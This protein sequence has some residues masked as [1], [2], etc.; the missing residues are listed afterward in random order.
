MSLMHL[1]KLSLVFWYKDRL[2]CDGVVYMLIVRRQILH[3]TKLLF[4]LMLLTSWGMRNMP[5]FIYEDM[6]CAMG[7]ASGS[8][9]LSRLRD[10]MLQDEE[11]RQI[12]W[13]VTIL[14]HGS[15]TSVCGSKNRQLWKAAKSFIRDL[16]QLLRQ[17]SWD[18]R[19]K[20]LQTSHEIL[21]INYK[22]PPCNV[23]ILPNKLRNIPLS[24]AMTE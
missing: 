5:F 17:T 18:R 12:L 10:K 4:F 2:F 8:C 24:I 21:E 16:C 15:C 3:I 6:I 1:F 14:Q 22:S 13:F 7:E 20:T 9:A 23:W 19:T 11:G